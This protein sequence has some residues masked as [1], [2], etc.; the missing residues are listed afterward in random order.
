MLST[1]TR[2][3]S[4]EPKRVDEEQRG[5]DPRTAGKWILALSIWDRGTSSTYER[6]DF[7]RP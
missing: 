4:F 5:D 3:V 6:L 1:R 2:V 7:S